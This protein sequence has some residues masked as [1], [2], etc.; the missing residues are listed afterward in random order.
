MQRIA[1]GASRSIQHAVRRK[2]LGCKKG[3]NQGKQT[4]KGVTPRH[5]VMWKSKYVPPSQKW[6]VHCAWKPLNN[7]RVSMC[8]A[9]SAV[10]VLYR[11][12]GAGALYSEDTTPPLCMYTST[13]RVI[14]SS[15]HTPLHK[16]H[17][18]V[19]VLFCNGPSRT[20]FSPFPIPPFPRFPLLHG[21]S[22]TLSTTNA[23]LGLHPILSLIHI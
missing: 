15:V 17:C 9:Q 21:P 23:P 10:P 13:L 22:R 20:L 12:V 8:A 11:T 19:P 14:P 7:D 6:K 16:W 5:S 18:T 1:C 4:R 2:W 3:A